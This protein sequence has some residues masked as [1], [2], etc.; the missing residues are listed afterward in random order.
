MTENAAFSGSSLPPFVNA[1]RQVQRL[2]QIGQLRQRQGDLLHTVAIPVRLLQNDTILE[3]RDDN[4]LLKIGASLIHQRDDGRVEF[5]LY[6]KHEGTVA[7]PLVH[8]KR[9]PSP[10]VNETVEI[11]GSKSKYTAKPVI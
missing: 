7:Q 9:N 6:G 5:M 2:S 4:I 10:T 1:L 8:H 3:S 11:A